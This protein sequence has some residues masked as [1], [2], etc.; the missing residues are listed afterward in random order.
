MSENILENEDSLAP[1]SDEHFNEADDK[2]ISFSIYD[3]MLGISLICVALAIVLLV[4]ELRGF[5]NF[6]FV[7]PWKTSDVLEAG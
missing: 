4:I 7:F 2:S 5:G 3:A 1:T 6:P